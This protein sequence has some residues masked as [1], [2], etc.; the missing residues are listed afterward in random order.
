MPLVSKSL[1]IGEWKFTEQAI[2]GAAGSSVRTHEIFIPLGENINVDEEKARLKKE[3]EYNEGF[4][5]TVSAKLSNE[6]FVNSAPAQVVEG[7]R[8]KAADAETKIRM[9]KETLAGL[10]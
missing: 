1:N 3:I 10:N 4:L 2:P 8:K 9:M 7:E 5:K 6:K